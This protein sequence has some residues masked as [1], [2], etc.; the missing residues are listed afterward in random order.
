[1]KVR[2]LL[3][4]ESKWTQDANARDKNGV[5]VPV[6]SPKA[7]C[8]CLQGAMD[9]CYGFWNGPWDLLRKNL[10]EDRF[11]LITVAGWNDMHSYEEVKELVDRLDI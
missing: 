10:P 7:C 9:K 4:D 3:S 11:R 5:D 2:E 1:M 6:Y 8:W